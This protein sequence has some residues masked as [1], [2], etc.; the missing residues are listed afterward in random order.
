M[1]REH[2]SSCVRR[3]DIQVVGDA[4]VR[5]LLGIARAT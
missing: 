2:F 1:S 4:A 5:E 3:D